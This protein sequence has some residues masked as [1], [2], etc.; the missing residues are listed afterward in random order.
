M[1][2]KI[3]GPADQEI[4]FKTSYDPAKY[5]IS[6]VTGINANPLD[7]TSE[8]WI[9][10]IWWDIGSAQFINHHQGD[11]TEST[12]NFNKLFT[13][14]KVDVYE[15]VESTLLPSEWDTQS[16]TEAGLANGISGTS[17]YG[18]SAYSVRRKYDTASQTFT[19]F[20]YYWVLNK[21]TVPNMESRTISAFDV[22]NY[23]SDPASQQY[24]F[25][26][27]LGADRFALY[28]CKNL[29]KGKDV[30]ISWNWWTI[31]N[32]EQN[33]HTHSLVLMD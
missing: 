30:G 23:I 2:G 17:K 15:W 5:T 18:D 16:G 6:T 9:G 21:L 12:Q 32:Q 7:Y 27:P 25:V 20:Y 13:G 8:K 1:Q 4:S 3:A 31:E 11:I 33:T 26:A 29:V 24:R 22:S 10:K 28:N 19:N 14:T